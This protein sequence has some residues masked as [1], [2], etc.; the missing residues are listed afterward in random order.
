[1]DWERLAYLVSHWAMG[2][3]AIVAIAWMLN[4]WTIGR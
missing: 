1:M 4:N 2:A 3:A